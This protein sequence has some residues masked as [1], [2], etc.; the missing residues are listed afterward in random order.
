ME[1]SFFEAKSQ[2]EFIMKI[3]IKNVQKYR[4]QDVTK[5][6]SLVSKKFTVQV[7]D[8]LQLNILS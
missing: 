6:L 4:P 7:N 5:T 3:C 2:S 8:L 1:Y